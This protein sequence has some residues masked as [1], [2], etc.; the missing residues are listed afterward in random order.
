ML[1][2]DLN[3]NTSTESRDT[4]NKE[5]AAKKWKKL[6]KLTTIWWGTW[7]DSTKDEEIF[8]TTKTHVSEAAKKAKILAYDGVVSIVTSKR[9]WRVERQSK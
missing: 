9:A 3:E 4:F 2:V 6:E 1:S 8:K 5:M 7:K